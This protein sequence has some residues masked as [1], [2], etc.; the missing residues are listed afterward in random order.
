RFKSQIVQ[1]GHAA[2]MVAAYIDLN[3][4]RAGMVEDAK[5]YR[6]CSYAEAVAGGKRA[7]KGL[8]NVMNRVD[9]GIREEVNR[10]LK[11]SDVMA[12]YRVIL[13]EEGGII[14]ADAPMMPGNSKSQQLKKAKGFSKEAVKEIIETGGKL[15]WAQVLR[16]KTRYFTDGLVIGS[17]AYVEEFYEEL[18]EKTGQYQKRKSG[19][20]RLKYVDQSC[21]LN[22]E[23]RPPE[24]YTMRDMRRDVVE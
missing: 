11:W 5:D 1:G 19:A 7:Q 9:K 8:L 17:K 15:S 18:K 14:E 13:A 10:D 22:K 20:R 16:C 3:P 6:W 21:S 12:S 24:I 4:V 23:R 2:R